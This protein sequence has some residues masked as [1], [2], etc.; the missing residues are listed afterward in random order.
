MGVSNSKLLCSVSMIS[1]LGG[2]FK[3]YSQGTDIVLLD[4]DIYVD[5]LE[6]KLGVCCLIRPSATGLITT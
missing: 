2:T 1:D 5:R 6:R 3:Q 4:V